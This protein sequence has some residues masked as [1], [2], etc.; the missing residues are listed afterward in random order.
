MN[1]QNAV[2]DDDMKRGHDNIRRSL[3][4]GKPD[5]EEQVADNALTPIKDLETRVR[6][7]TD[8]LVRAKEFYSNEME[9]QL[10][11]IVEFQGLLAE[12][13]NRTEDTD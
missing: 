2:F 5:L 11:Q 1:P 7:L 13:Q 8:G 10:D 6:E 9:A 4:I 3:Q 12:F